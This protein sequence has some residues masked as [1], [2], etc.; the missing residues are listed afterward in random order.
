MET[1]AF[2]LRLSPLVV[3][4]EERVHQA[5]GTAC[6][7]DLRWEDDGPFKVQKKAN[8]TGGLDRKGGVSDSIWLKDKE[9]TK[10]KGPIP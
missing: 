5:E 8:V 10:Q 7:G 3:E 2:Q 6:S 4:C 9:G 1:G